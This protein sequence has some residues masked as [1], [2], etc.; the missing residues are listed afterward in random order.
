MHICE[1]Q[2][3]HQSFDHADNLEAFEI[4]AVKSNMIL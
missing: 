3:F 2:V 4:H 1:K